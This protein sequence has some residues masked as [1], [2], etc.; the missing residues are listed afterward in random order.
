MSLLLA[1]IP[2]LILA[3]GRA[4]RLK[5]LSENTPK[6]LMP[7]AQGTFADHHLGWIKTQGFQSVILSIGYLGDQVR[8][9]C[10][11][12][13]KWGLKISY[14]EDGKLP[15]GTGGAVRAALIHNFDVICVT[16]GDTLLSFSVERFIADFLNSSGLAAMTIL[17]TQVPG[18]TC[19]IDGRPPFITYDKTATK[20]GWKHIDY[21]FL[22]L[23]RPLIEAF[24]PDVP[25]DLTAPIAKASNLDQ[26]L[27]FLVN[28]D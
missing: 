26:V 24:P 5:A 14:L 16:Y 25:L 27:G 20:P 18:H 1:D 7:L 21:G 9:Y 19:N 17:E 8:E 22:A 13:S 4:T 6:Y 23:R 15:L 10:G 11:D 3:G 12:G 2:L 28:M